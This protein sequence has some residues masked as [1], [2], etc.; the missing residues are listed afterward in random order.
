MCIRDSHWHRQI[1]QHQIRLQAARLFDRILTVT[2][3]TH[4]DELSTA[5]EDAM[6]E[7]AGR[8]CVVNDENTE[9]VQRT[10]NIEIECCSLILHGGTPDHLG[11]SV[12]WVQSS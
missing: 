7:L 10:P 4:D 6:E 3:F 1:Q 9:Q 5:V 2:C 11:A 8:R 12:A